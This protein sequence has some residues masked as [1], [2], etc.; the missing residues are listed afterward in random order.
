M[1]GSACPW[2]ARTCGICR[3]CSCREGRLPCA[4][5]RPF[6]GWDLDG[7]YA[8]SSVADE[9]YVYALPTTFSDER[10]G[11]PL[12]CAGIIGYRAFLRARFLRGGRL[13]IY[14]FGGRPI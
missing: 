9:G 3:F 2:L 8:P 1:T 11:A 5:I 4:S 13:G 12:L 7:G 10:G 6:A 14:G